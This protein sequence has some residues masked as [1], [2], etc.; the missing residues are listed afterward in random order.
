MKFGNEFWL[1]LSREYISPKLFAV[2]D[3]MVNVLIVK[4]V[5][6]WYLERRDVAHVTRWSMSSSWKR[7]RGA[8][9][10][11]VAWP[12][13]PDG[14]CPRRRAGCAA[15]WW[16]GSGSPPS[17]RV[18]YP[19]ALLPPPSFHQL[20]SLNNFGGILRQQQFFALASSFLC[21]HNMHKYI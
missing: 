20:K 14:L 12:T 11:G 9:W 19:S 21:D 4:K 13:W 7:S 8:T 1:I 17:N 16:T 5:T 15:P 10:K 6:W 2:R 3:Q 18:A